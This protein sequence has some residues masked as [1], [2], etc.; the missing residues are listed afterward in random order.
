MYHRKY[1]AG[2]VENATSEKK[3]VNSIVSPGSTM[4][5]EYVTSSMICQVIHE[6]LQEVNIPSIYDEENCILKINGI[7]IQF[8]QNG[9]NTYYYV[10]GKSLGYENNSIFSGNNY[11]TYITLKGDKDSVLSIYIGSYGSPSAEL[12]GITICKGTDLNDKSEIYLIN[13]MTPSLGSFFYIIKG[14]KISDLVINA[15]LKFGQ[16]LSN[17]TALN[18]N[19]VYVTLSPCI[20]EYG[21]FKINNCYIGNS[22][23][24]INSFYNI[25]GKCFYTFSENILVECVNQQLDT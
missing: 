24:A 19:G 20:S 1:F 8:Q 21:R 25:G 18:E 22:Q 23:L 10:N 17:N 6:T 14:D 5:I 12:R 16:K 4:N 13:M 11:R 9:P 2:S 15:S 7:T 3:T